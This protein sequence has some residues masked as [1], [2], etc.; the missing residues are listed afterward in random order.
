[1]ALGQ[2][3]PNDGTLAESGPHDPP[4]RPGGGA[5]PT[6]VGGREPAGSAAPDGTSAGMVHFRA[7]A[8]SIEPQCLS[9]PLGRLLVER[10]IGY[11]IGQYRQKT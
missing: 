3:R 4:D 6:A 2:V 7:S 11:T 5:G 8:V 10:V 1:M 9:G